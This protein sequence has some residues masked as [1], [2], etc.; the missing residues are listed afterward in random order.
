MIPTHIDQIFHL[1]I[2]QVCFGPTS[3]SSPTPRG[4]MEGAR[5]TLGIVFIY[6]FIYYLYM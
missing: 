5:E 4:V 6:L 2:V 3:T 1:H